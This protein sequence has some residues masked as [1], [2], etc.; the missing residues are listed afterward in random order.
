M[1]SAR[2]PVCSDTKNGS[3]G[4]IGTKKKL[5]KDA[6]S[7]VPPQTC[8]VSFLH[9]SWNGLSACLNLRGK[10]YISAYPSRL[11]MKKMMW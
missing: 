7:W 10:I 11:T 9:K 1:C 2:L 6:R 5:D 3:G 8:R 4:C